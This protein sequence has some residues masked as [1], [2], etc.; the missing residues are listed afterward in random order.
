[1]KKLFGLIVMSLISSNVSA[2]EISF[3]T[4]EFRVVKVSPICPPPAPGRMT[5][6]ALGGTVTVEATIGCLD[7][8]LFSHF[9]LAT[10]TTMQTLRAVSLVRADSDSQ[11]V[12]CT[13]LNTIRKT[14]GLP[15]LNGITME[16]VNEEIRQ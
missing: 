4:A 6:M 9:E 16:I 8:L 15:S 3:T 14:V 13:R 5:C 1:M 10:D 7:E 2:G 12:M 11:R